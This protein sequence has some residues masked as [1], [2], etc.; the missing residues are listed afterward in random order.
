MY[1]RSENLPYIPK[2][3]NGRSDYGPFIAANIPGVWKGFLIYSNGSDF[4]FQLV[5][6]QSSC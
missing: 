4:H 2:D 6:P 1:L 3:F 5:D